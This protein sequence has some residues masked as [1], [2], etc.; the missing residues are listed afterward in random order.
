MRNHPQSL[1]VINDFLQMQKGRCIRCGKLFSHCG[2]SVDLAL[3]CECCFSKQDGLIC[4]EC[5]EAKSP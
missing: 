4:I 3:P 5:T 2:G 1:S